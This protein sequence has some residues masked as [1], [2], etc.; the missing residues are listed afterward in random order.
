V[1]KGEK[2]ATGPDINKTPW[3]SDRLRVS[4]ESSIKRDGEKMLEDET[5]DRSRKGKTKP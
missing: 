1:K 3:V 2:A 5:G 4:R